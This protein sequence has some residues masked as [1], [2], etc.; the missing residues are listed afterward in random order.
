MGLTDGQIER[1]DFVDNTSYALLNEAYQKDRFVHVF[2]TKFNE[3]LDDIYFGFTV[4]LGEEDRH[5][6]RQRAIEIS[7]EMKWNEEDKELE[8][9]MYYVAQLNDEIDSFIS[10]D[11]EMRF[12]PFNTDEDDDNEED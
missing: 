3:I 5:K 1:N 9:D 6:L 7:K 12:H 4:N 8:W 10:K 2:E 11:E